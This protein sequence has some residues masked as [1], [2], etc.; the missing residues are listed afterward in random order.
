MIGTESYF[1]KLAPCP[2]REHLER[3]LYII[4]FWQKT[5]KIIH[6]PFENQYRVRH[7]G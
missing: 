7:V 6:S 2:R 1:A 5:Y 4:Y 3:E